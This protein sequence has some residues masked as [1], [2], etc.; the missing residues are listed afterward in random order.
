MAK[1]IPQVYQDRVL[2]SR[3]RRK[4]CVA[5]FT[6]NNYLARPISDQ[7]GDSEAGARPENDHW[8]ARKS[9]TP[10]ER[11][12]VLLRQMRQG[13]S[14]CLKIIDKPNGTELEAVLNLT[15]IDSPSRIGKMASLAFHRS[16]HRQ[17]R[18]RNRALEKLRLQKLFDG[19]GEFRIACD[20]DPLHRA[21]HAGGQQGKSGVGR[22]DIAQ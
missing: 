16:G 18:T 21:E 15:T 12:N 14:G 13:Q 22:S 17:H 6:C 20:L 10:A 19:M 9:S 7:R 11:A 4:S 2:V 1:P 8:G 3:S 5:A